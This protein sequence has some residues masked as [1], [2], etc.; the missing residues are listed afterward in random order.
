MGVRRCQVARDRLAAWICFTGGDVCASVGAGTA[1]TCV[2]W[3][4]WTWTNSSSPGPGTT[5]SPT[6]SGTSTDRA[7][8]WVGPSEEQSR[9]RCRAVSPLPSRI[10]A[11]G[12]CC[13]K[14]HRPP[15]YPPCPTLSS[16]LGPQLHVGHLTDQPITW[17]AASPVGSAGGDAACRLLRALPR[18]PPAGPR[19]GQGGLIT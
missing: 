15:G 13:I 14:D 6:H 10:K 1:R 5:I 18:R 19:Q 12:A 3:C 7:S 9:S 4:T 16:P 11:V 2:G 17:V 8:R